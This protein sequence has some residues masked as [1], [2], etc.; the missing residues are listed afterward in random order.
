[1]DTNSMHGSLVNDIKLTGGRK[2]LL[3]SN[4]FL[5]FG[6]TVSRGSGR[7]ILWHFIFKLRFH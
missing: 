4:D 2:T 6:A 5:T 1:M 7:S 3:E